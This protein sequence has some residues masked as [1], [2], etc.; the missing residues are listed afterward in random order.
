MG[1]ISNYKANSRVGGGEVDE[2]SSITYLGKVNNE[3]R[4]WICM[5]YWREENTGAGY[6]AGIMNWKL[7]SPG[8]Y[9]VCLSLV[10]F[11]LLLKFRITEFKCL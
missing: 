8:V 6:E 9:A 3:G 10:L 11:Y 5:P 1:Y 7:L 2:V 4:A